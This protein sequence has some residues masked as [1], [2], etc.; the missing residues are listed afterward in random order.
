MVKKG[1]ESGEKYPSLYDA[2]ELGDRVKRIYKDKNGKNT[3]YKGIILA[4][5]D[6]EIEIYW[7]TQDGKY[8]PD[9]MN[10]AFTTCKLCEIFEGSNDYSPIKKYS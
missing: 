5:E 3:E 4:I 6:N 7:D 2:F 9:N 1:K 8:R 10:L